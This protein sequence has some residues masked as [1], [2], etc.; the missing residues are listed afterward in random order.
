MTI[1]LLIVG[2][3]SGFSELYLSYTSSIKRLIS[4]I[5]SWTIL[6]CFA[7][8]LLLNGF[9]WWKHKNSEESEMTKK[10][11]EFFDGV[12]HNKYARLYTLLDTIRKIAL[13]GLLVMFP[14]LGKT[15]KVCIFIGIQWTF[16]LYV[17]LF[18]PFE[19]KR[20]NLRECLNEIMITFYSIFFIK[21]N[22]EKQWSEGIAWV[23]Y[24][25]TF[26]RFI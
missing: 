8:L 4:Y 5:F 17:L 6:F 12:K 10:F 9:I 7:S 19:M 25:L 21:Y 11:N 24:Y 26:F 14:L 18:R 16:C 23:N 2:S 1:E 15:E 13:C 20:D 3:I 22:E